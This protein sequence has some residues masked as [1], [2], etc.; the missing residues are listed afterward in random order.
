MITHHVSIN[1]SPIKG[2]DATVIT[3]LLRKNGYSQ[4]DVA[5]ELGVHRSYISNHI[6]RR[7]KNTR[8]MRALARKMRLPFRAVW[9]HAPPKRKSS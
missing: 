6:A 2:L 4:A 9:G 7:K 3:F 1:A 8:I 5:R